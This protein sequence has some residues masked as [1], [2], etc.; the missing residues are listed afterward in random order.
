MRFMMTAK[1]PNPGKRKEHF[2]PT[3]AWR[4]GKGF[5]LIELLVVIA[6]IAILAALLL[7]ALGRAKQQAN[8]ITCLNNLKQLT[9][10]WTLYQGDNDDRLVCN[11][12][13]GNRGASVSW[14][15]GD[16]ASDPIII[17][18]NN[19]RNGA[20]FP[21]S[22]SLGIYKCPSDMSHIT[23]TTTPRV[24]SYSI[25]I[26]M[27]WINSGTSVG[28][29]EQA[30]VVLYKKSGQIALPSQYSVFWDEKSDDDLTKNSIRNGAFGISGVN[31]GLYFWNVPT[32]R[33]NNGCVLTFADGHAESWRWHGGSVATATDGSACP[34]TDLD[35]LRIQQS[36][37]NDCP[38]STN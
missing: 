32:T 3:P 36:V 6:I 17:Q 30:K 18:T 24:R 5:T 31:H 27:N 4:A 26:A 38:N 15:V 34:A 14:C 29:D 7:P 25:S 8:K 13:D 37:N 20:L 1:G 19:I 23:G 33:H 35:A 11:W 2:C 9:L 22:T 16:C 10:C 28:S 12:T 21:Y